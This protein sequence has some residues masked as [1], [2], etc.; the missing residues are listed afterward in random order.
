MSPDEFAPD[1]A[2]LVDDVGLREADCAV[3]IAAEVVSVAD[4]YQIEWMLGEEL[5]VGRLIFV[6]ADSEDGHLR[7]TALESD[8]SWQLLQAGNAPCGPEVQDD[9]APSVGGEANRGG[10]VADGEVRRR[11]TDVVWMGAAIA[12]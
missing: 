3:E 7:Q 8:E 11:L 10:G 5:T 6:R 12:S 9:H 4:C 1:D 2:V